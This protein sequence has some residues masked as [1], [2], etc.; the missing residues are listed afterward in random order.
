MLIIL[1]QV[2]TPRQQQRTRPL[3][4]DTAMADR[5]QLIACIAVCVLVVGASADA[6]QT[7]QSRALKTAN[8]GEYCNCST[9]QLLVLHLAKQQHC[10]Q[11]LQLAE[12]FINIESM[13]SSSSR[14]L[15]V[16]VQGG[17]KMRKATPLAR[18]HALAMPSGAVE[19]GEHMATRN[20]FGMLVYVCLQPA[21]W[22]HAC[23][24]RRFC[25]QRC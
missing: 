9:A 8:A 7:R 6:S 1:R 14:A 13:A 11:G 2:L 23:T 19:L 16:T 3:Q 17:P 24:G 4:S 18:N 10:T 15:P 5:A 22:L 12:A 20:G 21:T 25:Q